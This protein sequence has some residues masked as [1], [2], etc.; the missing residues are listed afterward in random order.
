M[1]SMPPGGIAGMFFFSGFSAIMA[2]VVTSR[3]AM[4]A[5]SSNAVLT[6]LAGSIM[7]ALTRFP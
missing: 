7:P 5:A 3:P 4:D 1:S 6:T 2:S